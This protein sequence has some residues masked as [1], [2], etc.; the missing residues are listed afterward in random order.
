MVKLKF[1]DRI[2]GVSFNSRECGKVVAVEY[3]GE[4]YMNCQNCVFNFNTL[5]CSN[6]LCEAIQRKD[7]TNVYFDKVNSDTVEDN[8]VKD[9]KTKDE[10]QLNRIKNWCEDNGWGE[11]GEEWFD[12]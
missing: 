12:Y 4:N 1:I 7:N 3:I 2:I 8:K 6:N 5:D 10:A 9:D 11:Y